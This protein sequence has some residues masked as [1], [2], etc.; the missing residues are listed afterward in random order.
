MKNINCDGILV[1]KSS[2]HRGLPLL[3]IFF[4]LILF[5]QAALALPSEQQLEIQLL[6]LLNNSR[7]KLKL[8]A[9]NYD[10]KIGKVCKS[11]SLDM[12][13]NNFFNVNSP[14]NGDLNYQ[15]KKAGVYEQSGTMP[16]Y[17]FI[18]HNITSG[19]QHLVQEKNFY[20]PELNYI[21]IGIAAGNSPK[22]GTDTLWIT[23]ILTERVVQLNSIP[24]SVQVGQQ[25]NIS[26]KALNNF[27]NPSLAVTT[28]DGN[29][30][31]FNNQS[32]DPNAF[33]FSFSFNKGKGKYT[34]EVIV[35]HKTMGPKVAAVQPVYAGIPYP[36]PSKNKVAEKETFKTIDEAEKYMIKLVNKDRADAKLPALAPDLLLTNVA[37][38]HS[39]DMATNNFFAHINLN[40][41]D[42]TARYNKAGG[43]G[44]VGE[45][46][47]YHPSVSSAEQGLMESPGHRA[48][49]L[50]KNST[51]IGIGIYYYDEKYYI[52]QLFK[53]KTPNI[54]K[55]EATDELLN[56]INTER[57]KTNLA[58]LTFDP[59][60]SKSAAE[61]SLAMAKVGDLDENA[62]G[63]NFYDRFK[64]NGGTY[65]SI[66]SSFYLNDSIEGIEEQLKKDPSLYS[67]KTITHIGIGIYQASHPKYGENVLWVTIGVKQ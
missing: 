36:A 60:L 54:N 35:E 24:L 55:K 64:Q 39:Q 61:H 62:G 18:D 65:I 42:G 57:I 56:W 3:I 10:S 45:N 21:G 11:H 23:V 63:I 33:S 49:I 48:N 59:I 43:I 58:P 32:T 31:T 14:T 12:R 5:C 37:R 22:Y 34:L 20:K 40:G 2:K 44:G 46:I 29:V 38:L 27:I 1:N 28:P 25:I 26:G 6:K 51:H 47:A 8:P 17:I 7:V 19:F 50:D 9:F 4:T 66:M 67:E 13:D 53:K 52:T 15:L 16:I 30:E 41:E